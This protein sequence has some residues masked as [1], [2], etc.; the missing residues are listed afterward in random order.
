MLLIKNELG[1]IQRC[2]TEKTQL[3]ITDKKY[4]IELNAVINNKKIV[5]NTYDN[6]A[7]AEF[8]KRFIKDALK[9]NEKEIVLPDS[10]FIRAMALKGL[11]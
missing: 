4:F 3:F 8:T 9:L 11:L 2:I 5:L 10:N 6:L 1:V 7:G